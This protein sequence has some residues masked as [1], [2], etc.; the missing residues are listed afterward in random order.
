MRVFVVDNGGQ[1]THREYRVL[2]YL[3]VD[4]G[5][6]PNTTS[7]DY[8]VDHK[9]DALVLSGGSPSISFETQKL[10]RIGEYLDLGIP[11]LGICVGAQYI[12]L[13]YGGRVG[14]AHTPEYGKTEIEIIE[15]DEI[16][17]GLPDR[18][19]VWENHN[20]EVKELPQGFQLLASSRNC[21]IQ[22][23]R[24]M[25]K[26]IFGIQ[27]HPEVE[28]TEYGKEIFQNFLKIV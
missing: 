3:G 16:F 13:H 20:D 14:P 5:I 2:K 23:F 25:E 24:H 18:I 26:K 12:A 21:R 19:F 1:W 8:I 10:G 7:P 6:I 9:I 27:F 4:T 17:K 11:I 28:N 15:K 22:A